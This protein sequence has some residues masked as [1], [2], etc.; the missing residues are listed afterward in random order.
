MAGRTGAADERGY[1]EG[2]VYLPCTE[3]NGFIPDLPKEN[4][5]IIYLCSPN[6]PT[7]TVATKTN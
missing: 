6:N 5:D 1:Y 4:V 3:A 7:G 2:L